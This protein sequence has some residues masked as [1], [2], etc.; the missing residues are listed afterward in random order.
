MAHALVENS[1][2]FVYHVL[3]LVDEELRPLAVPILKATFVID[4]GGRCTP[5]EKQLPLLFEGECFGEDP[6]QSSYKYEPEVAFFKATSDVVIIGAAHAPRAG[7]TQMDVGVSVG[8][9]RKGFTVWGDR[10]WFRAA[11]SVAM[12]R[13]VPFETIPIIY[14]RAFGGWDRSHPDPKRHTFEPRNPVGRGLG[15]SLE[16]GISLPNFEDP[17]DPIRA[18]GDR[19]CPVGFGF[20]APNWQPRM[21]LAGTHDVTWLQ[22][23]APRLPL[24]FD[25]RHFNAASIGLT[26]PAYLRG[27][28]S[29]SV[30][31]MSPAG[32]VSFTLPGFV[33]PDVVISSKHGA[34]VNLTMKLDTLLIEPSERRVVMMWRAHTLL[35]TGPHDL[36]AVQLSARHVVSVRAGA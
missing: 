4:R 23:R 16:A 35:R 30:M 11:G 19:P 13:P 22:T 12:S 34:A 10:V 14:E 31:G 15:G 36:R 8:P 20:V 32:T 26:S 17:R 29:V 9:L 24:D 2:P 18:I 33:P 6:A 3:H 1:T 21:Q 7:T 27:D 25:R 5:A 28:E